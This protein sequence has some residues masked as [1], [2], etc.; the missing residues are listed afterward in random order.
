VAVKRGCLESCAEGFSAVDYL[1]AKSAATMK[2]EK[3][4]NRP[5]AIRDAMMEKGSLYEALKAWR[6]DK[7]D[8]DDEITYNIIPNKIL[9]S[10]ASAEPITLREL[11][12][13]DGM[14]PKRM[15]QYGEEIIT[16][17]RQYSDRTP[18]GS[19][20]KD[21]WEERLLKKNSGNTFLITKEM[22]NKGMTAEEISKERGL[23]LSTIYGHIT[24][25]VGDGDFNADQFIDSEKCDTIR[26]YFESTG[27][28][29][30][31]RAREV[32]GEDY[33]FWELRTVLAEMQRV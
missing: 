7:A 33:D 6:D 19:G 20:E 10:I 18:D 27:D 26:D 21:D 16:I 13:V 2:A 9:K 4:E 23:A 25:L 32:L 15:A 1:R 11:K 24:R 8:E 17:V 30:L 22:L 31:G 12:G 5:P 3:K 29:S 14:G 28:L